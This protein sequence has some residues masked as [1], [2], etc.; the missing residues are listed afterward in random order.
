VG[1]KGR[2][3]SAVNKREEGRE[4]EEWERREGEGALPVRKNPSS[5][6]IYDK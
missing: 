1:E 3:G 4:G 6:F 2:V 5:S